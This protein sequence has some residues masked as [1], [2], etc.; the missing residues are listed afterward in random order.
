[1]NKKTKGAIAAGAA[2]LLLAG[3]AGT[4]AAWNDTE[5]LDG[6]TITAGKL[7]FTGT[8]TGTWYEDAA[9]EGNEVDL[10]TFKIVP[11]DV[12]VYKA[13]TTFIAEGTNLNA[14]LTLDPGT[15]GTFDGLTWGTPTV[16]ATG[17]DSATG[18][19]SSQAGPRSATVETTVTFDAD[20]DG[21]TS[22]GATAALNGVQL[23]LQ[24]Q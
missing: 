19:I 14:T 3:G 9:T 12:L 6:G 1:M 15:A 8:T 4:F 11:G 10:E 21:V 5:T 13:T 7:Q 20:T 17:V 2:A 22:Q 24:Q 16:T 23:K 18:V